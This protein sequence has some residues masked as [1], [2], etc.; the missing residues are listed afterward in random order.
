MRRYS[1]DVRLAAA[2][3][4]LQGL[5]GEVESA[6]AAALLAE[7]TLKAEIDAN[8]EG[9]QSVRAG[10]E[11]LAERT[12]AVEEGLG[13]LKVDLA[14]N[15][16]AVRGEVAAAAGDLAAAVAQVG[17]FILKRVLKAPGLRA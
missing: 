12:A 1:V 7:E 5:H 15:V 3:E 9:D 2:D 16:E 6:A 10:L 14:T 17:W 8:S 11:V 13:D 4:D